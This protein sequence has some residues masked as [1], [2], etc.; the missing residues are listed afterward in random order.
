MLNVR[1]GADTTKLTTLCFTGMLLAPLYPGVQNSTQLVSECR[2]SEALRSLMLYPAYLKRPC[3]T[4][5]P[6]PQI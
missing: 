2:R 3:R 1:D 4:A 5:I 6:Q